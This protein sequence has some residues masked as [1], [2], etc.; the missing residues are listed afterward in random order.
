MKVRKEFVDFHL[1]AALRS[2]VKHVVE[3]DG[4]GRI[5]CLDIQALN[6]VLLLKG[7]NRVHEGRRR[8]NHV[9]IVCLGVLL[10]LR[11]GLFRIVLWSILAV[12]LCVLFTAAVLVTLLV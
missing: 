3:K 5:N 12:K 11:F 10:L 8:N 2:L 7:C 4:L 6:H 9:R 1:L